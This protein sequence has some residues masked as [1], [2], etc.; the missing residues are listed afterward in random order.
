MWKSTCC[1]LAILF[2]T[3][4]AVPVCLATRSVANEP[5]RRWK[6]EIELEI[7]RYN[8]PLTQLVFSPDGKLVAWGSTI[9]IVRLLESATGKLLAVL[10]PPMVG[11]V[12]SLAF[13]PD[14]KKLA[15]L[16]SGSYIPIRLWEVPSGKVL[17]GLKLTEPWSGNGALVFSGDGRY[18]A[19]GGSIGRFGG[20]NGQ[21]PV[22][23][24][25]VAT[26]REILKIDGEF[27][28]YGPLVFL[29]DH[30]TLLVR[31]SDEL[32]KCWD[33]TTGK[34]TREFQI[35]GDA[36]IGLASNGSVLA[37]G[38][39]NRL[40]PNSNT[41]IIYNL[42]TA[43]SNKPLAIG[44]RVIGQHLL[45]D[46]K[47]L[48]V[49]RFENALRTSPLVFARWDLDSGKEINSFTATGD[50]APFPLAISRDG[51]RT[52]AANDHKLILYKLEKESR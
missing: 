31:Y 42:E 37:I 48:I 34:V 49:V 23:T 26:G 25:D 32:V 11:G 45:G 4:L 30:R 52:A 14:G 7:D 3:A 41:I 43:K 10:E 17:A 36:F 51:E 28:G 9:G 15:C 8:G 20:F 46:G 12:A 47:T 18:L 19:A 22:R 6:K 29:P 24:W 1:L 38:G 44:P 50:G 40:N 39:A 27:A 5:P 35:P 33:V 2:I 21:F 13:S 16:Y